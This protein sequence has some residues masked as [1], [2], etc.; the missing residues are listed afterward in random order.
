MLN[1]A[2][3]IL[4]L[5]VSVGGSGSDYPEPRPQEDLVALINASAPSNGPTY[6]AQFCSGSLIAD[7][8]VL[9][10][11]HCVDAR[12][13]SKIDVLVGAKNLCGL[14]DARER[15]RVASAIRG[16]AGVDVAVLRLVR[17]S[18]AH[19]VEIDV[20]PPK[21]TP[22]SAFG[23][24]SPSPGGLAPCKARPVRLEVVGDAECVNATPIGGS[25]RFN[26]RVETCMRPISGQA[27]NMCT[28]DSGGPVLRRSGASWQLVAVVSWGWNCNPGAPASYV[29]SLSILDLVER[30]RGARRN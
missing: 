11:A 22:L 17:Q 20:T 2:L 6:A 28:G 9:T 21:G 4:L 16:P 3:L 13:P 7:D 15:I 14:T 18:H 25:R 27:L 26:G 8:L 1:R 19:P 10:A 12:D 5:A 24:G 30:I 29:N 23:W